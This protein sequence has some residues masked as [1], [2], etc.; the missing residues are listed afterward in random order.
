MEDVTKLVEEAPPKLGKRGPYR[1][2][3]ISDV[4]LI[5]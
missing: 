1:K 4:D 5:S 3:N 2:R